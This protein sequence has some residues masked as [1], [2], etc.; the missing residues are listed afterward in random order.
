MNAPPFQ[1]VDGLEQLTERASETIEAGDA[2]SIA[3]SGVVDEPRE[4]GALERLPRDDVGEHADGAGLDEALL[5]RGDGL[6][7]G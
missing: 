7:C 2:E 1:I 5:L 4:S 6:L 3:G